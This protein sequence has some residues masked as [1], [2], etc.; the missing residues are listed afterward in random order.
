[1]SLRRKK[2]RLR[3]TQLRCAP[4]P[5]VICIKRMKWLTFTILG[6]VAGVV[7]TLLFYDR[8][9]EDVGLAIGVIQAST[10][11]ASHYYEQTEGTD[12]KA[13]CFRYG[14][15]KAFVDAIE[16][17]LI[18]NEYGSEGHNEKAQSLVRGFRKLEQEGLRYECKNI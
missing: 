15:A 4:W 9:G 14:S 6:F 1:M 5:G 17:R 11:E 2:T 18:N 12:Q 16:K 7:T 10:F 13:Y 8:E 3:G